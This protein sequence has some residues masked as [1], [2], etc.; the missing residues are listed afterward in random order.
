M[1]APR[2]VCIENQ[3]LFTA[4]AGRHTDSQKT[5]QLLVF[6]NHLLLWIAIQL[7]FVSTQNFSEK[8]IH[9]F[10]NWTIPNCAR[11]NL[12]K[13][14]K[15]NLLDILQAVALRRQIRL[16]WYE[17]LE[18]LLKSGSCFQQWRASPCTSPILAKLN[19]ILSKECH[20]KPQHYEPYQAA[21]C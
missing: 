10:E 8:S 9:I 4:R 16:F 1:L 18:W 7:S 13:K 21:V 15:I 11:L 14:L 5:L 2:S 12:K 3:Y 17:N 6:I 19:V 20:W